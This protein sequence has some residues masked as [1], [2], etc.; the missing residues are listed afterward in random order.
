MLKKRLTPALLAAAL[1]W[2][3]AASA[4]FQWSEG[5]AGDGL[6]TAEVTYS[7]SFESLD[8]IRGGLSISAYDALDSTPIYQVDLFKIRVSDVS[9]FSV[10]TFGQTAFDTQ[11][12]LFDKDG[13]GVYTNDDSG[14]DLLSLLPAANALG[15]VAT[16]V[17]YLAIAFAGYIAQDALG[18]SLF[19]SGGTSDVL[20]GDPTA[21]GLNS[22]ARAY[23]NGG[24]ESLYSYEIAL[25]GA[26]NAELPEP[27][28]F[29]LCGLALA[30]AGIARR[31]ANQ[32]RA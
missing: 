22:W 7:A 29:A 23:D 4:G 32:A 5:S 3:M 31:K 19:T 2:P 6:P 14:F 8:V 9:T 15:P 20:G 1:A 27:A 28:T 26:T 10:R 24:A 11:L 16:D 12:Y 13:K 21:G 25:T 18:N 17:Y 30:A